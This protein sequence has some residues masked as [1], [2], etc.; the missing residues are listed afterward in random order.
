MVYIGMNSSTLLKLLKQLIVFYLISFSFGGCAFALLYFVKPQNILMMNGVY[1]GTYPVKIA[2]SGGIVGFII[3]YMS[4]K[5][6][7]SK[8]K[9]KDLIYKIKI[10]IFEKEEIVS[11]ILDTGNFLKDPI[12][13]TPV[14][15]VD[16]MKL[17]NILPGELLDNVEQ[18]IGGDGLSFC[19]SIKDNK[20]LS[21]LKIIPFSSIGKLNGLM[22]GIRVDEITILEEDIKIK[23]DIIVGIS[24]HK[25]GNYYS[26][27]FGLD[28][29]EGSDSNEFA[30]SFK[31]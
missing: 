24:S 23:K 13:Q 1:I 26:A 7:K 11:G 10:K 31:K 16:K 5:I 12:S 2:L 18:L 25:L 29:F 6:V 27:I 30:T 22:L 28:L 17:Y 19:N 4:F 21:R 14:I 15:I 9:K 8:I 3:T 20:Y